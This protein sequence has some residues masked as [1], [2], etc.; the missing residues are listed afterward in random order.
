M[1]RIIWIVGIIMASVLMT[2]CCCK[3]SCSSNSLAGTWKFQIDN[4]SLKLDADQLTVN[5]DLSEKRVG[6]I[7]ICNSFGAQIE[8]LDM[9]NKTIKVG[10][11]MSTRVACTNQMYEVGLISVINNATRFDV[12]GDKLTIYYSIPDSE[13]QKASFVRVKDKK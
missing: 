10:G 8:E 13:E 1:K 5:F 9:N 7:G 4:P 11:V 2:S 6:G 3:K 12:N